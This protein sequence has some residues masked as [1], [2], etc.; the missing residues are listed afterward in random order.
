MDAIKVFYSGNSG[1]LGNI[2]FGPDFTSSAAVGPWRIPGRAG[3]LLPRL[4]DGLRSGPKQRFVDADVKRVRC[5]WP[6]YLARFRSPD[7]DIWDCA[8]NSIRLGLKPTTN[9]TTTTSRPVKFCMPAQMAQAVPS[10]R[11]SYGPKDLQPRL[12]FAYTPGWS[13][14]HTVFRGAFTIS[15]YLEGTGTNLRLPINAPFNGGATAGGEFQTVYQNQALPSTTASDGLIAPPPTGLACPNLSCFTGQIF[16]L[17]DQNVQPAIDDQWNLTVQHQFHG[18]TTL[19]VGYVG[20][21]AYHLMVPFSYG[22]LEV[23]PAG[24]CAKAPCTDP[25]PFFANNPTLGTLI[26]NTNVSGTQS[27]GRMTYNALQAVLKKNMGH[28]LEYQVSYTYAKCMSNNTG[29]YGTWS[30]AKAS[31]T[32][33]PYWQNVYDPQAEWA[34]CYYDE[35]HNLTAYA[36]YDL[37]VGRGRTYGNNMNRAVDAVVGGWQVSPILTLAHRLP[38]G[39]LHG[40]HRSDRHRLARSATELQRHQHRVRSAKRHGLTRRRLCLV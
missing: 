10:T 24:S 29:Y 20:Q 9:K 38:P 35:T 8:T 7:T 14:G 22:Q 32:A 37:P 17:W 15:D 19:Q 2:V 4:A 11:G 26:G 36:V 23:A 12:G 30:N 31:T 33:S 16:R 21:T 5:F 34:P 25:S 39:A 28:G 27:N 18:E 13:G 40:R 3:G 1:E 6:G